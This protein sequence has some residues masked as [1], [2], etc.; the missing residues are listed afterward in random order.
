[1]IKIVVASLALVMPNFAIAQEV[2]VRGSIG[3]SFSGSPEADGN[4]T[5]IHTATGIAGTAA[6]GLF[7]NRA[8]RIEVEDDIRSNAVNSVYTLRSTGNM[9]PLGNPSGS[10]KQYS[11]MANAIYQ[12]P[13]GKSPFA[14]QPYVGAG[15]GYTRFDLSN[16]RGAGN[17]IFSLAN[18]NTYV[19]P[20]DVQFGSAGA[21]SYQGIVGLSVPLRAVRNLSVTLE[22]RYFGVGRT[23][24]SVNRTSSSGTTVNGV[25]PSRNDVDRFDGN[26]S[27]ALIGLSYRFGH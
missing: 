9:E 19:G 17:T 12:I 13:V 6:L 20:S 10:L 7:L 26:T 24:V 1:M 8:F 27:S 18:D 21:L 11:V 25:V 14:I 4:I 22:Y 15:I 3:P 2:Y 23:G 16:V 5:Q